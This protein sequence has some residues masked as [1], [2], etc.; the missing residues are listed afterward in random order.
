[1]TFFIQRYQAS[2]DVIGGYLQGW[3]QREADLL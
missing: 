3:V 1:M 2:A